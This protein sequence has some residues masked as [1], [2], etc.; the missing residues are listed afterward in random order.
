MKENRLQLIK[1]IS[2]LGMFL[3]SVP[4]VGAET[5]RISVTVREAG[6]KAAT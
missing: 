6:A 2:L 5:S 3:L 4:A 1:A